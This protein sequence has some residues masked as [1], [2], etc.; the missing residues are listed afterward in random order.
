MKFSIIIPIHNEE[1]YLEKFLF[2]LLKKLKGFHDYEVVLVENGSSDKTR[3]LARKICKQKKL[4]RM[5]TLPEGNYGLAVRTG[6]LSAKGDYLVLFDLDYYDVGFLKRGLSMMTDYG[7]VVGTK[8]GKG[9]QDFRPIFR[10][11]GSY[12]FSFLLKFLFGM[13]VSDTHGIKVISKKEF[14]PIIKK[15][16]FTQDIF[17][18]ELLIRGEYEGKRVGEIGVTVK[19]KREARSSFLKRIPRTLKNIFRLKKLLSYE[20]SNL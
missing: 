17:D 20:Y 6:F 18:T 16:Q 8:L 2:D 5:L 4:V 3:Q 12:F 13:K 7:A 10:R 15:T 14:T 1:E 19:E 9:A 11:L